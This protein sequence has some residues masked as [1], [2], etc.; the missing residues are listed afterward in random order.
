MPSDL[1]LY[2][3]E[4]GSLGLSGDA[5]FGLGQAMFAGETTTAEWEGTKLRFDLERSGVRLPKGFHAKNDDEATREKVFGLIAQH[6]PRFDVTLLHKKY[7]PEHARRA[8]ET[9]EMALYQLAW[10][11]HFT[12]QARYL[13]RPHHRV[14]IVAASLSEHPKRQQAATRAIQ[15]VLA[16]YPRLDITLCVWDNPTSWGLQVADYGLWAVQ[17]DLRHHYCKHLKTISP[18]IAS[19]YSPWEKD[20]AS[21]EF[22]PAAEC[23]KRGRAIASLIYDRRGAS[24]SKARMS[25]PDFEDDIP[26]FDDEFEFPDDAFELDDPFGTALWGNAAWSDDE[27]DEQH[28]PPIR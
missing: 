21:K 9:D 22:R 15:E 18:L 12:Y 17:R 14:F 27:Y 23:N 20:G 7:L 24:A 8:I 25:S 11:K 2:L 10:R 4:T 13:L 28:T 26:A 16:K 3:D 5:Y 6:K 1:Y 19:V